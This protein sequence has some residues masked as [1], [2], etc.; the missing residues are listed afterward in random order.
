MSALLKNVGYPWGSGF[1][2]LEFENQVNP[3]G[4]E[5]GGVLDCDVGVKMV[6]ELQQ[7]DTGSGGGGGYALGDCH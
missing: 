3:L 6:I 5:L 1:F 2:Y 4:Y 7:F